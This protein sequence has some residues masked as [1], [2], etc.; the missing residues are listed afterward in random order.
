[1]ATHDKRI[2]NA[3]RFINP[4]DVLI[5]PVPITRRSLAVYRGSCQDTMSTRVSASEFRSRSEPGHRCG[6]PRLHAESTLVLPQTDGAAG[7]RNRAIAGKVNGLAWLEVA[8]L[9]LPRL[10]A[11]NLGTASGRRPE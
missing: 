5:C 7:K 2:R 8:A 1:M 3:E 9:V 6:S 11:R 10:F 4:P